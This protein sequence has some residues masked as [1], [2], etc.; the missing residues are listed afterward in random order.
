MATIPRRRIRRVLKWG[1]LGLSLVIAMAWLVSLRW[2]LHRRDLLYGGQG[3]TYGFGEGCLGVEYE[4]SPIFVDG[5]RKSGPLVPGVCRAGIHTTSRCRW[6]PVRLRALNW[7]TVIVPLWI[8]FLLV[9]LPTAVLF[10]RYRRRVPPGH[11]PHCGYDLVS[12][13]RCAE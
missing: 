2:S 12:E 6:T 7:C 1:G 13:Q 10:W 9:A 4:E 11:C 3:V 8:P 5:Q